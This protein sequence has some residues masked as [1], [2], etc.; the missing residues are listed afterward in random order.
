MT[1]LVK[2]SSLVQAIALSFRFVQVAVV[3]LA[4][5]WLVAGVKQVPADQHAVVLR[6]GAVH[7]EQAAGLVLSW[8]RPIEEVVLLPGP[9]KQHSLRSTRF[10]DAP[11][12]GASAMLAGF[13]L[14]GGANLV[15]VDATLYYRVVRPLEWLVVRERADAI[16]ARL[17]E[18]AVLAACGSRPIEAVVVV[19][20]AEATVAPPPGSAERR[21]QMSLTVAAAVKQG[22]DALGL[23]IEVG[24]V[25]LT[26]KVPESVRAAFEGSV[27]AD[28]EAA[29][30]IAGARTDATRIRQAAQDIR[31]RSLQEAQAQARERL[32]RA[33]Q[34][35]DRIVALT[36]VGFAP[37]AR[38][39]ALVRIY[40]ERIEKIL[41]QPGGLTVIDA[42]APLRL[43]VPGE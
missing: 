31:T 43:I 26:A 17:L 23:G 39:L 6:F 13:A 15:H 4:A 27:L 8:P 16:L 36:A 2:P 5:L 19:R 18:S 34:D 20:G 33:H 30:E 14:T 3:V 9:Q 38:R 10:T 25:D 32:A 28:A 22:A 29:N 42:G 12:G 40:H 7:R 37:A 1:T 24:R 35:T 41:K 11:A 21:E